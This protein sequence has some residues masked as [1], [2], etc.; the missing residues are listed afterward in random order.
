MNLLPLLSTPA[1]RFRVSFTARKPMDLAGI[2]PLVRSRLGVNLRRACCPFPDSGKRACEGCALAKHCL[3]VTLFGPTTVKARVGAG[4]P[5]PTLQPF[6]HGVDSVSGGAELQSGD[7]ASAVFTLFGPAIQHR[8]LFMEAAASAVLSF[9]TRI[10]SVTAGHP[11]NAEGGDSAPLAG[12]VGGPGAGN[13]R[14]T[15]R[16]VSPVRLVKDNRVTDRDVTFG[17]LASALIRRLRDLKRSY[18]TDRHM[19]EMGAG[20][21]EAVNAVTIESNELAWVRRKRFSRRQ[22]KPVYLDGFVGEISFDGPHDVFWPLIKAG[23]FIHVGKSTSSG[24]GRIRVV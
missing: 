4:D 23:E 6:V 20:F 13:G 9:P 3:Y 2:E 10:E 19:G 22:G 18:G 24:C 12:W 11:E 8:T 5:A 16:F 14:L 15:L 17:L 1:A 7:G 21:R